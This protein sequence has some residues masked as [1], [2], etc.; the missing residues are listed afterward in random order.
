MSLKR[1]F[2]LGW[3]GRT[4]IAARSFA[5]LSSASGLVELGPEEADARFE[6]RTERWERSTTRYSRGIRRRLT[7]AKGEELVSKDGRMAE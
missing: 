7:E 5:D 4:P 1:R 6:M 2:Y 3:D